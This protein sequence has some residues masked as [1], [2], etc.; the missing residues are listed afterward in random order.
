MLDIVNAYLSVNSKITAEEII[1]I[2][3]NNG[4]LLL[5]ASVQEAMYE[6]R[7]QKEVSLQDLYDVYKK[8][9]HINDTH[10]LD[11]ILAIALSRQ[12]E[13]TPLWLIMVS[14]SG[15]MKSEQLNALDDEVT[16]K[17]VHKFTDKTLVNGYKDKNE[18]PDLAPKLNGKIMLIPDMAEILQLNPNIKNEVWGQL[19][20]LYDGFAGV[21]TGMGTDVQYKNLRV[22]L[23]GGSTPAIDDQI[24]IHQSLGTRE[25]FY[26]P[27]EIADINE[28]MQRVWKNEESE[29]I[30]RNEI[31]EITHQFLRGKNPKKIEIPEKVEKRIMEL[32]QWLTIM[33]ATASIDSYS[34]ELRGFVFPERPT[35]VLKQFK[36]FYI[37][38]MSLDDNYDSE[39]ALEIIKQIAESSADQLRI[40]V[41][42][43]LSNDGVLTT[44]QVSDRLKIGKKSAKTELYMLWN[45]GII[46]REIEEATNS[47]GL[48][49]VVRESW[50]MKKEKPAVDENIS[51]NEFM[52]G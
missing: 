31:R 29:K 15:D 40:R 51:I 35:R 3:K 8:W 36:R 45:M 2:E 48:T 21:Q 4:C 28:L 24:L 11:V 43:L 38:L 34:G 13:G 44:S 19:R 39:K 6:I 12:M 20:N 42:N 10:R 37:C 25:L 23:I 46:D 16:T 30:M 49:Y 26:R 5:Q 9:F 18:F 32:S 27:K 1:E 17:I 50:M 22:T 41:Y 14:N 33:R 47:Y 52:D 7:K